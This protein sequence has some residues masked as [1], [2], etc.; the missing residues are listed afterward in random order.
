MSLKE[1]LDKNA[2]AVFKAADYYE[3]FQLV[4]NL[5]EF[6]L[7]YLLSGDRPEANLREELD[8]E[9]DHWQHAGDA[10]TGGHVQGTRS[11]RGH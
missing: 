8:E 10:G 1:Q 2:E 11:A 5:F 9:G 7:T 3:V 4:W 6:L